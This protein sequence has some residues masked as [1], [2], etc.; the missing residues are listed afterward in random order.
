MFQQIKND[1]DTGYKEIL[2]KYKKISNKINVEYKSPKDFPLNFAGQYTTTTVSAGS[3]IVVCD[4]K[5]YYID[6]NDYVSTVQTST[7]EYNN[8]INFEPLVSRRN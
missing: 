8:V 6:S 2:G 4:D 1:F 7:Y 3:I 5:S